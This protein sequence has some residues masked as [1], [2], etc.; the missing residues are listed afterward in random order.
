MTLDELTD[1]RLE[2]GELAAEL[3]GVAATGRAA[4]D[5]LREDAARARA[6][7]DDTA[8][9][10]RTLSTSLRTGLSRALR[11]ALIDG[12]KLSDV[13]RGLALDVSRKVAGRAIDGLAGQI[14]GAIGGAFG[15]GNI[16]AFA[17][18]GV[19]SGPT[20]FPMQGGTGLAG[21]AGPEAILPLRRGADGRLGVGGQGGATTVSITIQTPDPE[22]FR[23]SQTQIAATLTRAVDR[24]R[25]NL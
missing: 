25:R 8:K 6:S 20:L 24:G 23:R 4:F 2:T 9:I 22:A 16:R 3:R 18:G 19:I 10:T 5:G 11:S 15:A 1:A 21:E 7:L 14:S 17:Q 12:A 13:L